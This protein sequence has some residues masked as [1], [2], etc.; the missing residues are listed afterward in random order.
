MPGVCPG[1]QIFQAVPA[2]QAL[3]FTVLG[4]SVM[5]KSTCCALPGLGLYPGLFTGGVTLN[6]SKPLF[7]HL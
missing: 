2:F 5:L 4:Y 7:L 3:P 6:L 1:G